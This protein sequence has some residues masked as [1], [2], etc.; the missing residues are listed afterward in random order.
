[1]LP[2]SGTALRRALVQ[3]A[4]KC[5]YRFEDET[6]VD[7]LLR[8]LEKERGALPLL[9]FAASLL[10]EKRDRQKG[11]LTREAYKEIGGVQG[12][13]AQHAETMMAKLGAENEPIVREIFRNLITAKQTRIARDTE[14]LLS[15]FQKGPGARASLTAAEKVLQTLI[16]TRLLTSFEASATRDENSRSRVEISH[17]SLITNWPRLVKWQTQEAESSRFRDQLGR[18]ADI[19]AERGR[20]PDL[21]WTGAAYF[22][23]QLWRQRYPGGLTSTEEAFAAFWLERICDSDMEIG[24]KRTRN[25]RSLQSEGHLLEKSGYRFKRK[26]D[27]VRNR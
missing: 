10:W 6:L 21:L 8:D 22:E 3:P 23:Y 2:L 24:S 7:D 19:W 1:M 5:G 14:E 15:V 18:A 16:D 12:T 4:L 17:E 20:S 11:Q 27:L 13:L 26:V 9:A 25:P